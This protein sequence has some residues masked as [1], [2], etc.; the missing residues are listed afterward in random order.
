MKKDIVERLRYPGITDYEGEPGLCQDAIAEIL[1]LR[2][3]KLDEDDRNLILGALDSLGVSLT[4]HD[5]QWT[6]GEVAIYE[7]A[8]GLLKIKHKPSPEDAGSQ[9]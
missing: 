6:P 8:I 4:N 7:E 1:H 2:L 3:L 9:Q 5:H